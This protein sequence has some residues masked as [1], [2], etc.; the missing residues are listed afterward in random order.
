MVTV[1]D[2]IFLVAVFIVTA[3]IFVIVWA[4]QHKQRK[5][6]STDPGATN[7]SQTNQ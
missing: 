4:Y 5:T 2:Y 1:M 6:N 3:G 7:D